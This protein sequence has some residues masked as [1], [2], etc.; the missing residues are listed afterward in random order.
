MKL[1]VFSKLLLATAI[2]TSVASCQKHPEIDF[3]GTVIN[4]RQCT[5]SFLDNN[6]GYI[7][8]LD[9]PDS[10]GGTLGS[11]E[12]ATSNLI[13]LYEP[14]RVIHV[15]EHIHGSF[16]LDD[17]YS[18]ANCSLHYSDID[19]PEGVFTNVSVD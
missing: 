8:Q 2:A 15:D 13:V 17:K 18:R 19:L 6:V 1:S 7:V 5:G 9:Y 10:I 16:Y 3:A 4:I 14:N 12:D 11:G